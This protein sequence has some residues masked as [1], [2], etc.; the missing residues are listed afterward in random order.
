MQGNFE[1]ESQEGRQFIRKN[2]KM[3]ARNPYDRKYKAMHQSLRKEYLAL[4]TRFLRVST[5]L[6]C[7]V[8]RVTHLLA[9]CFTVCVCAP[10]A[11]VCYRCWCRRLCGR[12]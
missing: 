10:C 12:F 9:Q 3:N 11:C 5:A 2:Q 1:H 4:Y 7:A 6:Q 8:A